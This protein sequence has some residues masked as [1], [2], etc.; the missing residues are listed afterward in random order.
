MSWIVI[1]CETMRGQV[2]IGMDVVVSESKVGFSE[3][4]A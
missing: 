3:W 2:I 1:G 4:G